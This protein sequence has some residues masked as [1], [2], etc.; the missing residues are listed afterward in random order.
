MVTSAAQT[1]RSNS[2][3]E[4]SKGRSNVVRVPAKYS[5]SCSQA[6]ARTALLDGWAVRRLAEAP[7]G[8]SGNR[9]PV[10]AVS[11]AVS[12]SSPIGVERRVVA[13]GMASMGVYYPPPNRSD[14]EFDHAHDRAASRSRRFR[15]PLGRH[16]DVHCVLPGTGPGRGR[17][18][19]E[20]GDG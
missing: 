14:T 20:Q 2:E 13:R 18:G 9:I 5:S 8:P 19:R 4:A 16:D 3:P 11:E 1:R 10:R 7:S 15:G 17:S 12:V 6:R